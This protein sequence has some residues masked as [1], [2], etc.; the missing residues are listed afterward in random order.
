MENVELV[1]CPNCDYRQ[2][3]PSHKLGS[4]IIQA[5]KCN[6][7]IMPVLPI[8][9]PNQMEKLLLDQIVLQKNHLESIKNNV[10]FFFWT[11]LIGVILTILIAIIDKIG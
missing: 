5:H 4:Y 8:E 11:F 10:Q 6:G 3:R 7:K 9:F 2:K 1:K